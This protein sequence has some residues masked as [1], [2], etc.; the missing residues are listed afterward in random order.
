MITTIP[1]LS[2]WCTLPMV[3]MNIY[4]PHSKK[5]KL[6]PLVYVDDIDDDY[7]DPNWNL[8]NGKKILLPDGNESSDHEEESEG[9]LRPSGTE[10]KYLVFSNCLDQ[11]IKRCP[12]CEVVVTSKERKQLVVCSLLK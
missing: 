3:L 5:L 6:A 2:P 4:L 8:P 9:E 1:C 12:K 11:V 10:K 7:K